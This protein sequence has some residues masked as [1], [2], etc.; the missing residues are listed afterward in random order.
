MH[1][2]STSNVYYYDHFRQPQEK[3]MSRHL[4]IACFSV[5]SAIVAYKAGASRIELCAD[6]DVGGT[7]P[8]LADLQKVKAAVG[9]TPVHVMIRPRG[10]GFG[11]SSMEYDQMRFDISA[12]KKWADGFVFGIL[13]GGSANK[14]GQNATETPTFLGCKTQLYI[15]QGL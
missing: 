4:E 14:V 15:S 11:Y 9:N 13:Q 6:P 7:T 1:L 5:E 8:T 10:G 2:I 12:M 3:K